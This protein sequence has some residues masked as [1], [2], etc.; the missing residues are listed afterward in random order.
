MT[1][2]VCQLRKSFVANRTTVDTL[3]CFC[4]CFASPNSHFFFGSDKKEIKNYARVSFLS[5]II[6]VNIDKDY[7]NCIKI[8]IKELKK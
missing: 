3:I 1:L 8:S 4:C 5:I 6:C 7:I 2:Q